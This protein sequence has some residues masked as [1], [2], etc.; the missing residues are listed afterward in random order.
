MLKSLHISNYALIDTLDISFENGMTVLTGETGAGKSIIIGALSLILGQRAD[1]KAIKT[2][3]EKCIIEAEFSINE[4]SFLKSFFQNNELDYDETNCFIRREITNSGKSRAFV[5][6]TPVSLNVV[7]ELTSQLID[8]HSQHENLLISN[9]NYQLEMVD[10]IAGNKDI[11]SDYQHIYQEWIRRK[12]ELKSVKDDAA[13]QTREA[14]YIQFQYGQLIDAKLVVEEQ[15][16]LENEIDLLNH[17]EEIKTELTKSS[18][19]LNADNS[20]LPLLKETLNAIVKIKDYLPKTENW[21][22]RLQ[23]AYIDIKDIAQEIGVAA[24]DIEFNPQRLAEVEARLNELYGLQKKYKVA[25]VK[26]LIEIRNLLGEQLTKIDSFDEL[27]VSL[28]EEISVLENNLEIAAQSLTES[29]KK[30]LN[31]IEAYLIEQLIALGMPH[32]KIGVELITQAEYLLTGKDMVKILFSANKNRDL[33]AVELIASGGEISRLMLSIKSL[34]AKKQGLP[35]IIFDEIDTGVSGEIAHR[36][37]EIMQNMSETMQ[38]ICITHLPQIAAKGKTH[39][40]VYKDESSHQTSTHINLLTQEQRIEEIA[41]MLSGKNPS[42]A[43]R[44]NAIELLEKS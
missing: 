38:V 20:I 31:T 44:Q 40:K 32:A 22:E 14:D 17:A 10:A 5:N 18:A 24:E 11:L 7:K 9:E 2:D 4:Y 16:E 3:A 36:M 28:T 35:T 13:K 1:T 8:I 41:E 25:T 19:L 42:Q 43:A 30:V 34:V 23:S 26:E 15:E 33:Q 29:R 21:F 37:G 27:I 12:N 39:Y 6:D